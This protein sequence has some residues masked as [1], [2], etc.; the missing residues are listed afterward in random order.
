[1]AADFAR[2][3]TRHASFS[4]RRDKVTGRMAALIWMDPATM[5][6]AVDVSARYTGALSDSH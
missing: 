6:G 4:H 2:I 5:A 3:P 1:M